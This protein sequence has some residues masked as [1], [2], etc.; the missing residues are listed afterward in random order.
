MIEE[1][2]NTQS[3]TPEDLAG[4]YLTFFLNEEQ[5]AFEILRV[6]EINGLMPVTSLPSSPDFVDGVINLRGKVI[7]VVDL[8]TKFD[9]PRAEADD[10]TCII[11][12]DVDDV[13]V[14]VV[15]DRV[16]E[17]QDFDA[18]Q[19]EPPPAL[20]QDVETTVILGMGKTDERA[21]ILLNIAQILSRGDMKDIQ[22][23][24]DGE[25]A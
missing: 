7:P 3:K 4:K 1:G 21:T 24:A 25:A 18:A 20:G 2:G 22:A 8:R 6:R 19:I 15:V 12:V 17:V 13:E 14:G 16:S 5:Y 11:V 10:E 9:M 23:L